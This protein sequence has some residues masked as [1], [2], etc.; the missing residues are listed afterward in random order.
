MGHFSTDGYLLDSGW[1]A[2]LLETA[3]P[4]LKNPSSVNDLSFYAHHVSPHL[5]LFGVPFARLLDLNGFEILATHEAVFF[6]LFAAAV[7]WGAYVNGGWL[8]MALAFLSAVSIGAASNILLQ[9]AGYPHYEIAMLS[10]TALA[11]VAWEKGWRRLFLVCV[12]WLPLIREDGGFYA[13]FVGVASWLIAEP[14]RRARDRTMLLALLFGGVAVSAASMVLKSQMF[15]GFDAFESNF[16]GQSWSHL[17]WRFVADRAYAA[18]TNPNIVPV[19]L[20]CCVLA[21]FDV[22]YAAGLALLPLFLLHVLSV[23][24]EHGHFTLYFALPWLLPAVIWMVLLA[25][26]RGLGSGSLAEA[27]TIVVCAIAM[28]APAQAAA[29]IQTNFWYVVPWSFERPILRLEDMRTFARRTHRTFASG[30]PSGALPCASVGV[31]ALIPND[32][33]PR[34]V[35][36]PNVGVSECGTVLLMAGDMHSAAIGAELET[37]QFHRVDEFEAVQLWMRLDALPEAAAS[38]RAPAR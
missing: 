7:L 32:L 18:V 38:G 25:R 28:T 17:S 23:R 15:P 21:W 30:G 6:G 20:G 16:A 37:R 29:G 34:E 10:V 12:V 22:R 8:F 19:L 5:F 27:V 33:H 1:L 31:A 4:L 9:A 3:D 14:D 35:I 36:D 2:Y 26:R 11:L 13:A 24:D